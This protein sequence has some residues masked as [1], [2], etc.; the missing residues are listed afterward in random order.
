MRIIVL[1]ELTPGQRCRTIR[2]F[3]Q[4]S[5]LRVAKDAGI[6]R[7]RLSRFE[8]DW[9]RL[10]DSEEEALATVLDV[11]ADDLFAPVTKVKQNGG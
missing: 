5:G 9:I 8:N 4:I 3:K 1:T 10:S 7:H 2:A 11:S 6:C